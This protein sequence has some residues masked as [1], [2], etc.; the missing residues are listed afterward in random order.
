M[1]SFGAKICVNGECMRA[2]V[3]C[4]FHISLYNN[5]EEVEASSYAA[6]ISE[7]K[8]LLG[9]SRTSPRWKAWQ[10]EAQAY[11]PSPSPTAGPTR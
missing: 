11:H 7:L 6:V 3:P 2:R 9:M 10:P 8:C 1:H 4:K 5:F